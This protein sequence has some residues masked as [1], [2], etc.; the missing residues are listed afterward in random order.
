[1]SRRLLA[2][3][4]GLL[5]ALALAEAGVRLGGLQ[6]R[7]MPSLVFQMSSDAAVHRYAADPRLVYELAPSTSARLPQAE[8]WGAPIRT[9]HI[10]ALGLRGAEAAVG[11]PRG[12]LRIVCLGGSNT[13]GA[14]VSDGQ[15]WPDALQAAL[16]ERLP[17]PVQVWNAGVSGWMTPQKVLRAEQAIVEWEP[18]LL[19]FQLFNTGPRNLFVPEG[20]LDWRRQLEADPTLWHDHLR[21]VPSAGPGPLLRGSALLRV[22]VLAGN[23]LDRD[24]LEPGAR[25]EALEIA[26]RERGRDS[27]RALR[28]STTVPMALVVVPAGGH[29]EWWQEAVDGPVLDLRALPRPDLPGIDE[30]HPSA[31]AYAWYGQRLADLLIAQGLIP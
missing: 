6:D 28:R 23:R 11:K 29:A 15:T 30:I 21:W 2:V 14:A 22:A 8:P 1:M 10:N 17:L 27:Y 13:F 20:G 7:W 31:A 12:T 16:A 18:D 4:L 3:A 5:G 26:A 24:G 19:L 25:V 9:V